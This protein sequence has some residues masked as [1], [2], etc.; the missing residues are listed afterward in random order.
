MPQQDQV[1]S[2]VRQSE[3]LKKSSFEIHLGLRRNN[4][5]V[6][7]SSGDKEAVCYLCLDGEADEPLR[8]DCACRGSDAGFVHLS[9]LAEYAATKSKQAGDTNEFRKPWAICPNCHQDYQNEFAVDIASEFVSFVRN[10]YPNN[11]RG[12]VESLHLKLRALN[13]MLERLQPVQ[14]REAGVTANV[15]ISLIERMKGE[16]SPLPM[17]YSQFEAD[18]FTVHGH[19]AIDEGTKESARRAVARFEKVL[20]VGEAIGDNE[21]IAIAKRNIADAKSKYEG[22]NTNEELSKASQELY[23]LRIAK[24]GEENEYTIDA[25]IDYAVYLRKANR[26][27]EARDLL[28]KLLATSKQVLGSDHN[29]TKEVEMALEELG[30]IRSY[31]AKSK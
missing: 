2:A 18:A 19:I 20:K 11:T 10:Q 13:N 27:D 15:I 22:G 16:V 25:G 12:Q 7:A 8:R 30:Y 29:K 24:H 1:L 4:G 21:G 9:C 14:K 28:T 26:G 6:I 3:I 31:C 23:E 5:F 17:R